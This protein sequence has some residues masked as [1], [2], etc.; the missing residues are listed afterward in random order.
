MEI[1][2]GLALLAS[3]GGLGQHLLGRQARDTETA[4]AH[5]IGMG[6]L[7]WGA[8][9]LILGVV[10]ELRPEYLTW[11]VGGSLLGWAVPRVNLAV[12]LRYVLLSIVVLLPG[13]ISL[14][15]GV[16]STDEVYL[17]LGV[18]QQLL[19]EHSL[20][21]GPLHPNA[22][23]PLTLSMAF[24][25]A[26][27]TKITGAAAA[28]N[29]WLSAALFTL[30]AQVARAHLGQS[31]AGLVA[32]VALAGS[33]TIASASGHAGSDLPTAFAVMLTMDAALRGQHRTA[34]MAAGLALSLKYTAWAPLVGI[35]LVMKV[36][37]SARVRAGILALS[38]VSPWW[39]RNLL[40]GYHALFPFMGWS[41]PEMSFQL[42]TKYG[43]GRAWLDFMWLPYRMVFEADPFSFEFMGRLHP[44]TVI[45]LPLCALRRSD[46]HLRPWLI[47]ASIGLIGWAAG[48][49]W[50]RY[51]IPTLPFAALAGAYAAIRVSSRPWLLGL[52]GLGLGVGL[53]S[54]LKGHWM[55]GADHLKLRDGPEA[56]EA[57]RFCND[58]LPE[59]SRIA[60][61]FEWRSA[62]VHH[63]QI[64]GSV[65]DHNPTR[66][67]LLRNSHRIIDALRSEGATHALVRE[68]TFLPVTYNTIG[69]ERFNREFR[70]PIQ[71][72]DHALLMGADLIFR[73]PSHRVYR[74]PAVN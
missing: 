24:A 38:L 52:L 2:A 22:S 62:D 25:A 58:A 11:M 9:G 7:A 54:G 26:M 39:A 10:G 5:A 37:W 29:W 14:A 30:T 47:V 1:L 42:L 46:E 3:L 27:S 23:R 18:P 17:H 12:P 41:E 32:S 71:N 67:F 19:L 73:S 51:L 53:S 56:A 44:Y 43:A 60:M 34:G 28:L 8:I 16:P 20:L 59:G 48:P 36:P 57:I 70:E 31:G 72:L 33:T 35:W 63:R 64:L 68:T 55:T 50:L 40:S 15:D 6:L 65:E 61:L 69:R 49:H 66:H 4:W 21:G 45:L 13:A 74:I